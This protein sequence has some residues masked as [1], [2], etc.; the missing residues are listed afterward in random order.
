[1]T[2]NLQDFAKQLKTSFDKLVNDHA[3][4]LLTHNAE[5]YESESTVDYYHNGVGYA[6]TGV[7][8]DYNTTQAF[9]DS[10]NDLI[11]DIEKNGGSDFESYVNLFDDED[12]CKSFANLLKSL[13]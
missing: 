8:Y 10:A 3:D 12:F 11:E 7:A 13:Y 2:N 5:Q 9:K 4:Y 6:K 1:M